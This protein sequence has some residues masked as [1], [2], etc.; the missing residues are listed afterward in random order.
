LEVF[1]AAVTREPARASEVLSSDVSFI[2]EVGDAPRG[3]IAALTGVMVELH[4]EVR[5]ENTMALDPCSLM[6]LGDLILFLG[7]DLILPH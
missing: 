6:Q 3:A 5:L 2:F 7:I 1:A 4:F